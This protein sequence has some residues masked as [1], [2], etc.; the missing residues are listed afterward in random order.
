MHQ[1][2]EHR[3]SQQCS[4]VDGKA[5]KIIFILKFLELLHKE[6]IHKIEIIVV[7]IVPAPELITFQLFIQH[8]CASTTSVQKH[9]DTCAHLIVLFSNV[10]RD[11]LMDSS[12]E[13]C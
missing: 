10:M 2:L 1:V 12:C 5:F 7:D 3:I 6:K 13:Q 11:S 9:S 8:A 4:K